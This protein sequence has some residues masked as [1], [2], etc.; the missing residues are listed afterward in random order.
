MRPDIKAIIFDFGN[1]LLE[2][3]PRLVYRRFFPDDPEAMEQ[4]F[5]EVK[6]MEWNLLQDQGRPF[7]EGV[8][9]LSREFPHYSHLIQAYHD[10]WIDSLGD[11]VAGT[12]EIMNELKQA[13]YAL[14][15]LSNWSAETFPRARQRHDFFELLD[16]M[17]I[18]GEVGHVK[19][20]PEIF[21]IMLD[22]IGR[23][24][25][26]CLFVDDSLANIEQAQKMGFAA[27]HFQS[28]EQLRAVLQ[29]WG[30]LLNASAPAYMEHRNREIVPPMDIKPL[31]S[32]IESELQRQSARLDA[33]RTEPFHQMVT[34]HMGWT[35]EGAGPEATGKRI[36][37]LLVLLSCASCGALWEPALPA[38]AAVELVHNFSLVHD[39]IQDNS[40]K[41]RGRP[42]TWVKWGMP[43]AINVG[44][45]LFVMSNQA[46][47]D[48]KENYAPETVLRAAEILHNTCLELTRGQFLDMSYEERNDLGVEDYWPMIAGKTAALLSTCCHIGALLGGAEDTRQDAYRAFGHYLGLAFQ[49]QDDVLGI[50]GDEI[51]TG[52]ST[53]SDLIEGKNSL[54]VLAGLGANARFAARW[55]QGPIRA[56]EVQDMARL[57]ASEGGY[58][59]A[60]Q[61]VR[62]MT[63]LALLSLREADP[64]GEAGDALF[65]LADRLLKRNQ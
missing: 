16:D 51:M 50:W 8:A 23:P 47:I 33:P 5:E 38:A 4:F 19:P 29:E 24:A 17:V 55:R 6:F 56:E 35:G 48:L 36:R 3:N 64:Q 34:Y 25:S 57:L 18:S 44:D 52:K 31:L 45:S 30:I 37:P 40:D 49:V 13:G 7:T 59:T 54:P 60:I 1:V 27:I 42:T 2:W 63:D 65:E 15:G 9:I 32:A 53:A 12:V 14:Y 41:R 58:E 62:Q 46:M 20:H 11:A 10:H 43:M 22:K 21:Q 61:A 28:P 39:D 26:E